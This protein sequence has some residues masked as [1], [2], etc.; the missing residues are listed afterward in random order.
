MAEE[1]REQVTTKTMDEA[2]DAQ[3]HGKLP[4][5]QRLQ[6]RFAKRSA[7][8]PLLRG[9]LAVLCGKWSLMPCKGCSL[10]SSMLH[11]RFSIGLNLSWVADS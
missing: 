7:G 10:A 2:D 6:Q 11:S 4:N 8:E 3:S 9:L 5:L 1:V